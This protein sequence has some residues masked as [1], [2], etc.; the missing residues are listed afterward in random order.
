MK[1]KYTR[2]DIGCYFDGA[3]GF[4]YNGMRVLHLAGAHGFKWTVRD[5]ETPFMEDDEYDAFI[6]EVQD[7]EDYLNEHTTRPDNTHW[8]WEDGDFGL[9]QYDEDGELV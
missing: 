3:F 4:D 5:I 7:A 6:C 1:D 9:W 2:E 8:S